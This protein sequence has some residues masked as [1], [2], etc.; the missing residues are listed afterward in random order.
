[1][2]VRSLFRFPSRST[3]A[4]AILAAVVVGIGCSSSG[5]PSDGSGAGA[6]GGG[7]GSGGQGGGSGGA[8]GSQGGGRGGTVG[9]C[10]V[11]PAGSVCLDGGCLP[12]AACPTC[13]QCMAGRGGNGGGGSGGAGAGGASAVEAVRVAPEDAA[14]RPAPR[15]D[16]GHG[17]RRGTTMPGRTACGTTTCD[18]ATQ[19]CC[20]S[21]SWQG[22]CAAKGS[23]TSGALSCSSSASCSGGQICCATVATD[24]R[25]TAACAAAPCPS[26][27]L[28]ARP[29]E[30]TGGQPCTGMIF[31]GSPAVCDRCAAVTCNTSQLC[32][33]S[34][35]ICSR[36]A[37]DPAAAERRVT[38]RKAITI[39]M[40]ATAAF[41]ALG[42][43]GSL[44]R[45]DAGATGLGGA[46]GAA[47]GGHPPAARRGHLGQRRYRRQCR[48]RRSWWQCARRRHLPVD[49]DTVRSMRYRPFVLRR[50]LLW[51]RRVVRHERRH[52]NMPVWLQRR[53]S[54]RDQR[55][56]HRTCAQPDLVQSLLLPRELLLPPGKGPADGARRRSNKI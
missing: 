6:A 16:D 44:A 13:F 4:L 49:A 22:T 1:M 55:Q 12:C 31:P 40:A 19:D 25:P 54:G 2:K 3:L 35:G 26:F 29:A 56:L 28:C 41:L 43:G 45:D 32:C 48:Q 24:G 42:C 27:Q 20:I 9:G 11:C 36:R 38:M 10:G 52:A 47:G 21:G 8:A 5:A 33:P 53:L 15:R 23:C 34:S 7:S 37:R 18:A 17:R 51:S 30:C 39:A 50:R 14:A 46:S